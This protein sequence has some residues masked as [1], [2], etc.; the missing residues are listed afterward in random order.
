LRGHLGMLD[1]RRKAIAL[2]V[3]ALGIFDQITMQ[4]PLPD[5]PLEER[6][7]GGRAVD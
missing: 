7:P 5:D 6:C 2:P 4:P 1:H 3:V